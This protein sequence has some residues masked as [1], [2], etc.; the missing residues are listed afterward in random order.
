MKKISYL[1][2]I[3]ISLIWGSQFF[4]V[5]LVIHSIP[6]VTLAA[7]KAIIGA[8]TLALLYIFSGQGRKREPV[9]RKQSKSLWGSFVWIGLLEAVIPFILIGW[10]QQTV[11]SSMA[12]ILM[13]TI[14]IFTILFVKLFVPGET[15][16]A[17]KWISVIVGMAGIVIL[18]APDLGSSFH[19]GNIAG[20]LALVGA[21]VSFAGSLIL[22]KRLPPMSSILAMR[23]VL[24]AASVILVP[25][26]FLLEDPL[27]VAL[28]PTQ[29]LAVIILG[30]F[31]AGI[32]YMLY[33]LL[34]QRAGA[35]FASL[36][37]YLVPLIG[38]VLGVTVLGDSLTWNAV[39]GLAVILLS[40]A[41]GGFEK[42]KRP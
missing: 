1:L 2:L 34:I 22:I 41:L 5:D 16:S 4:L 21:A 28:T 32:V 7:V 11:S 26:A 31:H 17:S 3:S 8:G 18:F 36:N 20:D 39:A 24:A 9:G 42:Q 19:A 27:H 25:L 38:I 29:I 30:S 33:N 37:N 6:P 23:N 35:T 10:G 14:P 15:I 12:A 40:L 13:G